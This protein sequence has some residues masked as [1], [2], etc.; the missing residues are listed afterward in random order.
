MSFMA[1]N[2]SNLMK[3]ALNNM[4]KFQSINPHCHISVNDNR[5][6]YYIGYIQIFIKTNASIMQLHMANLANAVN[7]FPLLG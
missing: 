6:T 3:C 2:L 1:R 7:L 4:Q 5:N